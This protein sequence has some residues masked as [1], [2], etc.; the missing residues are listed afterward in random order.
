MRRL[1]PHIA[2]TLVV[3][4]LLLMLVSWLLNAAFPVSGVRSLL[5]AEGL[6]WLFG[7]FTETLAQP[8]LVWIVLLSM[9]YGCLIHCGI[10]HRGRSYRERQALLLTW[11]LLLLLVGVMALLT[12]IPHAVLLSAT[13]SLW[14]SPF[15]QS[16]VPVIAF[17]VIALSMV[18]G[19][20]AG[21]YVSLSAVY[22]ALLD[23]VRL[24]APLFLFY[25]LLIQVCES[26][27]FVWQ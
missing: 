21:C 11:L 27:R 14:P 24:A 1:L 10:F 19:V 7:H 22:E 9:A 18:Y 25:V 23:G 3:L 17:S 13:G 12:L 8:L 20:V 4:Q 15:S 5:S 26:L 6:R 16:L 2:L